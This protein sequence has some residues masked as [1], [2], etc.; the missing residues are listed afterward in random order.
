MD[1]AVSGDDRQKIKENE[2]RN[3]YSDL[4][5]ELRKQWNK[6]MTVIL[7]LIGVLGTIP[8]CL[9]KKREELQIGGG[10]ETI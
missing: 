3:K 10:I 8:K 6:K 1:F 4:A 5:R 2:K 7:N 9:E